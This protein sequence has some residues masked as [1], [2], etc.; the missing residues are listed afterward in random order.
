[1]MRAVKILGAAVALLELEALLREQRRQVLEEHLALRVLGRVVVD[2]ADLQQREVALAVLRRPNEPRHGVARAQVEA[3]N[4]ARAHVDVVGA[5]EIRAVGRAQEAEAVLQ[6]LEHA[7]AEDVLAVLRVRLQDREDD[8]LLAGAREVLEPHRLRELHER[9]GGPRLQLGQIHPVLRRFEVRGRNDVELFVVGEL[10]AHRPA[11]AAATATATDRDCAGCACR[12]RHR[13]PL[14]GPP[15]S[16]IRARAELPR[17]PLTIASRRKL[18][19][20]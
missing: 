6:D 14:M 3:A 2:L 4:L 18:N 12:C 19:V 20:D 16:F 9:R 17:Y 10:L 11:A 1:M 8:V 5:R 13:R 7:F 15:P